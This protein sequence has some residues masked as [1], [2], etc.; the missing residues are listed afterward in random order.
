MVGGRILKEVGEL[1]GK[2]K[3]DVVYVVED[4]FICESESGVLVVN[5]EEFEL[6]GLGGRVFDRKL[7][8]KVLSLFENVSEVE[9][10]G[11]ENGWLL[12]HGDF[13]VNL[14]EVDKVSGEVL[15]VIDRRG[16][17]VQVDV[18][19]LFDICKYTVVDNRFSAIFNYVYVFRDGIY[20]A[21]PSFGVRMECSSDVEVGVDVGLLKLIEAKEVEKIESLDNALKV[22]FD[23]GVV[24]GMLIL[25]VVDVKHGEVIK[26]VVDS[27]FQ[28]E[29][30]GRVRVWWDSE[31]RDVVSILDD[32]DV[33]RLYG[34]GRFLGYS[35]EKEGLQVSGRMG[36]VVAGSVNECGVGGLELKMIVDEVEEL[37][38]QRDRVIVRGEGFEGV[39]AVV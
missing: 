12:R 23:T 15:D 2:V 26:D 35:V 32:R 28:Q 29:V 27:A 24:S 30:E 19:R 31:V 3:S 16:S 22:Y 4:R 14:F 8:V 39:V 33:V 34:D 6:G 37:G 17:V 20:V 18:E 10:E 36:E 21:I 11:L 13:Q 38:F 9:I 1:V 5:V 25:K 7:F